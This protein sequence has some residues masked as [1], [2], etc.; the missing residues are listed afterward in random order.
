MQNDDYYEKMR[1]EFEELDYG[2]VEKIEPINSTARQQDLEP[3][4]VE[5][6]GADYTHAIKVETMSVETPF[7]PVETEY[8]HVVAVDAGSSTNVSGDPVPTEYNHVETVATYTSYKDETTTMFDRKIVAYPMH[9]YFQTT[10]TYIIDYDEADVPEFVIVF[11]NG[12]QHMVMSPNWQ[13][14]VELDKEFCSAL[15]YV[16]HIGYAG[17]TVN[18]ESEDHYDERMKTTHKMRRYA[19]LEEIGNTDVY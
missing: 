8:S 7:E 11:H 1:K 12:A 18:Y 14:P 2:T 17:S 19:R 6:T 5:L 4:P 10:G 15:T 13:E 3:E 9:D 16:K